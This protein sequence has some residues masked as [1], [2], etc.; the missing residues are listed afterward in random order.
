MDD[1]GRL[2]RDGSE[3]AHLS[4]ETMAKWIVGRLEQD[5]VRRVVIPHFLSRCTVCR[6]RYAE[7]VRLQKEVGHW[8]EEI[9]VFEGRMAPELWSQLADRPFLE[10]AEELERNEEMHVWALCQLLLRKSREAA[11]NDLRTKFKR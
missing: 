7:I 11:F 10:Q 1:R 9:A 2:E 6:E 8:D 5:E 3:D 4:L